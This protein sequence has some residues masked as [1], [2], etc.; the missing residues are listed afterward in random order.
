MSQ[1]N[2]L[3]QITKVLKGLTS[4]LPI[5][6]IIIYLI[7]FIITEA[8]LNSLKIYDSGGSFLNN[9]YLKSGGLF[10]IYTFLLAIWII[11]SSKPYSTTDNPVTSESFLG[12]LN[13]LSFS[14][15]CSSI[16]LLLITTNENIITQELI[17]PFYFKNSIYIFMIIAPANVIFYRRKIWVVGL[18][19]LSS[20]SLFA[21]FSIYWVEGCGF[22]LSISF[23]FIIINNLF[24]FSK[25]NNKVSNNMLLL[26]LFITVLF[27]ITIFGFS[28][29][30]NIGHLLAGGAPYTKTIILLDGKYFEHLDIDTL[31]NQKTILTIYENEEKYYFIQNDT[32]MSVSKDLVIVEKVK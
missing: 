11:Y 30:K 28:I 15:V 27:S 2:Y 1:I 31:S 22:I 10:T 9:Y 19:L 8:H 6:L 17:P 32:T 20:V 12:M 4:I 13:D 16:I 26:G 7:G 23:T 21:I 25:I 29:Y 5:M 24:H 3:D 14:I 18:L